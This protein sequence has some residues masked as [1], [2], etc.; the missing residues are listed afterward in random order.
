VNGVEPASTAFAGLRQKI[1]LVSQD[2]AIFTDTVA[3]N[4]KLGFDATPLKS[5]G[6]ARLQTFTSSLRV[7]LLA[8][9]H[10]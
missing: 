1:L 9:R 8:I 4:I 7:C 3:N 2:T 6:R 10:A 5:R